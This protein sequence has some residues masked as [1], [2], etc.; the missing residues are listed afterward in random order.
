[1]PAHVA[2][3][4]ALERMVETA[5]DYARAAVSENTLK[6]YAKDW[7]HFTHWCQMRG[8]EPLPPSHKLIGL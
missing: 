2:G 5:Q 6:A 1:M 4:G 3:S 7:A 8:A